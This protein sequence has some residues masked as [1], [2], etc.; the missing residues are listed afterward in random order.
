MS[1]HFLA[2]ETHKEVACARCATCK[3]WMTI[4]RERRSDSKVWWSTHAGTHT[5]TQVVCNHAHTAVISRCIS[6]VR[7]CRREQW[8][9]NCVASACTGVYEHICVRANMPPQPCAN[10]PNCTILGCWCGQEG[11]EP[12]ALMFMQAQMHTR[13]CVH[14][15]Q[16]ACKS[17]CT[18]A[19]T[20]TQT[21]TC[22][23]SMCT[24]K[25]GK[26]CVRN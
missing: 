13:A 19:H 3:S 8:M 6:W 2:R 9:F 18:Q 4:L 26:I 24:R 14:A 23:E 15:N 5:C 17:M 16:C 11:A 10:A 20:K 1:R 21:G 12:S 22:E 7:V 25:S